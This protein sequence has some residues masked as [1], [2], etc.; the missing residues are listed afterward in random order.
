LTVQRRPGPHPGV[1]PN[2]LSLGESGASSFKG[3]RAARNAA[4][5]EVGLARL[6][7]GRPLKYWRTRAGQAASDVP[8]PHR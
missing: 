5:L 7:L 8:R 2:S 1:Q 3:F 4:Y 6:A